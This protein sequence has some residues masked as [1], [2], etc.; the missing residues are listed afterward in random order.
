MQAGKV[1][2][3]F[4]PRHTGQGAPSKALRTSKPPSIWIAGQN[5]KPTPFKWSAKVSTIFEKNAR[6]REALATQMAVLNE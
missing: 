3:E 2:G 1:I 4:M 6:A 5:A